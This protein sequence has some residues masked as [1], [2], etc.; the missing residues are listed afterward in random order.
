[1]NSGTDLAY[2]SFQIEQLT[3]NLVQ[4]AWNKFLA[5]ESDNLAQKGISL[6]SSIQAT[7]AE[8]QKQESQS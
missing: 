7:Q 4:N 2:G 5:S 3:T 6:L 8:R 1:L